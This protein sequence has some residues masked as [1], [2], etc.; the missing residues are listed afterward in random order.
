MAFLVH[1]LPPIKCFVRAEF[2]YNQAFAK[3]GEFIPCIWMNLKSLRGQAWRIQVYL[4]EYGALYDKLP[5]HA[6]QSHNKAIEKLYPLDYLQLWDCPAYDFT[7]TTIAAL[8][9]C[10]V[11]CLMKDRVMQ[12]G[13][14]LFT[15]DHCAPDWNTVDSSWCETHEE[16]K[17]YNFVRLDNGQFAAQPN[18]RTLFIDP[19]LCPQDLKRADFHVAMDPVWAVEKESRWQ[20]GAERTVDYGGAGEPVHHH[21]V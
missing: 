11:K 20:L 9:G 17:S 5:L 15:A 13:E 3:R 10:R 7:V 8:R 19:A 16:H 21:P 4:P 14:Y 2:L 1:N 18:N 12:G 6:F